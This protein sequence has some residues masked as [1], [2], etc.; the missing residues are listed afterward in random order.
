MN[1][2]FDSRF[3]NDPAG[4]HPYDGSTYSDEVRYYNF[5]KHPE[6]IPE[7]LE[8]FRGWV[9]YEAVQ[10]FYE[11]LRWLN[12]EASTLESSD[13]AFMGPKPE[14]NKRW[15]KALVVSGRLMIL[16]RNLPLN[17]ERQN[18]VML[19]DAIHLYLRQTESRLTAQQASVGT[20]IV[21]TIYGAFNRLGYRLVI[22]FWAWGDDDGEAMDNLDRLFKALLKCLKAASEDIARAGMA[23]TA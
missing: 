7:V 1:V 19:N 16:Y 22:S 10:T 14:T 9:Q 12:G 18:M 4:P 2:Y 13:C 3:E 5:K 15:E 8:D 17:L 11:L 20:T 6:L 23:E 21:R